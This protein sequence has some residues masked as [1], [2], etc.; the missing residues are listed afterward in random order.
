MVAVFPTAMDELGSFL[1]DIAA[2]D[3]FLQGVAK[4]PA[5]EQAYPPVRGS[6]PGE[7]KATSQA[8]RKPLNSRVNA[9]TQKKDEAAIWDAEEIESPAAVGAA[10]GMKAPSRAENRKG[11]E[12]KPSSASLP[13][14]VKPRQRKHAYEYFNQWDAYDVEGEL[15][16]LESSPPAEQPNAELIQEEGLPPGLTAAMLAKMPTVEIERRAINEKSKGNEFYKA[17]EYKAALKSYT[18]SLRLQQNNAVV[19]A[20]RGMCYL[21]LKQYRQALADTTAAI[22]IDESYTKAYL[23]RG[24]AHRRL[25]QH[26]Q[27]LHD[28]DVVLAREPH[29]KEAQEH[30]RCSQESLGEDG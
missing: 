6:I 19:Y 9:Q 13:G 21:K 22:Q 15:S 30:R 7:P 12:G 3:R 26:E 28:L 14:A 25:S 4:E 2:R 10:E 24:I 18:H 5:C 1:D 20:N 16:K 17:G 11:E 23:R 29:N 27:A 8:P